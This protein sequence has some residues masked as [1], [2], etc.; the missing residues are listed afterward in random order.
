MALIQTVKNK[1]NEF[2]Q[3]SKKDSHFNLVDMINDMSDREEGRE[4]S[5]AP[6]VYVY[7]TNFF[8][9]VRRAAMMDITG[10]KFE[11]FSRDPK[12]F[13][14]VLRPQDTIETFEILFDTASDTIQEI[15][16]QKT[17]R[18]S[19]ISIEKNTARKV[20]ADSRSSSAVAIDLNIPTQ[21]NEEKISFQRAS[22]EAL[23]NGEDPASLVSVGYYSAISPLSAISLDSTNIKTSNQNKKSSSSSRNKGS[24]KSLSKTR[25]NIRSQ[26]RGNQNNRVTRS[27]PPKK[28]E[29]SRKSSASYFEFLPIQKEFLHMIEIEKNKISGLDSFYVRIS[30]IKKRDSKREIYAAYSKIFHS[31]EVKEF[32]SNP[33]APTLKIVDVKIGSVKLLIERQD[34]T[35]SRVKVF[36]IIT[37]P[38]FLTPITQ[39]VGILE[40][41]SNPAFLKN[42]DSYKANQIYFVD[43]AIDNVYPNNVIY[44]VCVINGDGSASDFVSV[45]V[46][47]IQKITDPYST[48]STPVSI[49]AYNTAETINIRVNILSKKVLS[50]RLLRQ[51]LKRGSDFSSSVVEIFDFAKQQ[52]NKKSRTA[53]NEVIFSQSSFA[54]EDNTAI[55]GRQYRYFLAYLVGNPGDAQLSQEI[56]SDEDEIIIRRFP[57]MN[58]PFSVNVSTPRTT[59]DSENNP[60]VT[61]DIDVAETQQ[62]FNTVIKAVQLAGIGQ[63]FISDL[64][65]DITKAKQMLTFIVERFDVETGKRDTFGIFPAGEFSDSKN[66]RA[67]RKISAPRPGKKYEYIVKTCLQSPSVFLQN[68]SVGLITNLGVEIKKK[69]SRFSR[70]I[71]DRMGVMPP[72]IDVRSGKDIESLILET[73]IG[74]EF[75]V[76][77][78]TPDTTPVIKMQKPIKKISY[79]KLKWRVFGGNQRISYFQIFGQN[80]GQEMLLGAVAC[81]DSSES[82]SFNDYRLP[83][84]VGKTIYRVQAV[85][86]DDDFLLEG[87]VVTDFHKFSVPE[88]L[89][90]GYLFGEVDGVK[91]SL[92]INSPDELQGFQRIKEQMAGKGKN[93]S[94]KT[95]MAASYKLGTGKKH[96]LPTVDKVEV[97]A[98]KFW[99]QIDLPKFGGKGLPMSAES[100]AENPK[101]VN[102]TSIYKVGFKNSL[103]GKGVSFSKKYAVGAQNAHTVKE[104]KFLN[105]SSLSE[106]GNIEVFETNQI[107]GI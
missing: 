23:A 76:D 54:V 59:V 45:A 93:V 83:Y 25:K 84:E 34:P 12:K 88:N 105:P 106:D 75:V 72:D 14:S 41:P 92:F 55:L 31:T 61:F 69:S 51:E 10:I 90:T 77:I 4:Y 57:Y 86:Y 95:L 80:D 40:F 68:A 67:I 43:D 42:I 99:E 11:I 6:G 98:K 46:P 33:E 30:A 49:R 5:N 9:N 71:Y 28:K 102:L 44:R 53:I 20:I 94:F 22:K 36:R 35:L 47:S 81:P 107:M 7:Q 48:A 50:C 13:G 27:I 65:K 89:L 103:Q 62:L 60:A 2:F 38:N 63:E 1:I 73:Q 100:D 79:T 82:F 3:F 52:R 18:T 91:M 97:D 17:G 101:D 24:R 29:G 78:T 85:G 58:V 16:N 87:K 39:D 64:T 70:I 56:I 26:K 8:V 96:F 21:L 66:T 15:G 19:R 32:L 37:N 74:L 104:I